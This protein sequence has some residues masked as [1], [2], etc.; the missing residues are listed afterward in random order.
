MKVFGIT[1]WKN[2]G[3]TTL[4]ERLVSVMTRRGLEVATVKH[5]HHT[6][7]VDHAGKDSHRH[8]LAGARQVLVS[9]RNRWALMSENIKG[10]EP[11][12]SQL[13]QKLDPVDLVLIEGFKRDRHPKIEARRSASAQEMIAA[14]DDTVVAVA[15]DVPLTNSPVPVFNLDDV[16]AMA[17]FI[18]TRLDLINAAPHASGLGGETR[19]EREAAQ[20]SGLPSDCFALPA[21]TSLVNVDEALRRLRSVLKPVTHVEHVPV[22]VALDRILAHSVSPAANTAVDG[23]GF[24]HSSVVLGAK[25]LR[26]VSGRSAAGQPHRDPVPQG[27]AVRVLTGALLPPGVDTV[28]LQEQAGTASDHV[29]IDPPPQPGANT[30]Q[31][32]E[33]FAAGR[34]LLSAGQQLTPADLGLCVAAGLALLPVRRRLRVGVLSTGDELR[35]AGAP[36]QDHQ[37]F[38]ANRPMLLAL[39]KKWGMDPVDLGVSADSA[40]SVR[41]ALDRAAAEC[42][43]VLTSGG[44]S[45]GDEDHVSQVLRAHG[46]L[47]LWRVAMKPGR[48]LALGSWKGTPIIGLP[49]NPVAALICGL[50][51]GYPTLRSMAGMP[52]EDPPAFLL[53]AAFSKNKRPGRREYLRAR[54]GEGNVVEVFPSEGSGRISGLSWARGLVELPDDALIVQPGDLVRYIPFSSFGL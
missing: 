1:G 47:D 31:A 34:A 11:P 4:V 21:G 10:D 5:A 12:L 37:T 29:I 52:W 35:A 27:Q 23:Y 8:R 51:F 38:D 15:S 39:L 33:D 22:E 41:E 28:V 44:A 9:S 19:P 46:A 42:D 3:K 14:G 45:A 32:G 18:C 20:S 48:P 7:D 17:D 13:L 24:A 50:V 16:E 2:S 36:I 43:A 49:G 26:L 6:F 54:L 25:S 53:P 30:R 40:V